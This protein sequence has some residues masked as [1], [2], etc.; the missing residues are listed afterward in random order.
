MGL[1]ND[2]LE[3]FG[4][5][6]TNVTGIKATDD[7]GDTMM[8]IRPLTVPVTFINHFSETAVIIKYQLNNSAS[9]PGVASTG[10]IT[11]NSSFIV[12]MSGQL[13]RFIARDAVLFIYMNSNFELH[14]GNTVMSPTIE[15]KKWNS[16]SS[17]YLYYKAYRVLSSAIPNTGGTIDIYESSDPIL[18]AVTIDTLSV[19]TNDTYTAPAGTAYSEVTVNVSGG[20]SP[21]LQTKSVTPTETAQV[22][23][24]DAGYDGLDEV[25][26]AAIS[27]S[28]VGSGIT[29][30][31]STDMTVSGATV[32]APS[33]YYS[34]SASETVSSGTEGTPTATKGTVSNHSVTITPSVTNTAGYIVGSTKT[35]TAVTVSAAELVSGTYVVDST[36]VKDVTDYASLLVN[37]GT[38]TAPS[39]IS[40]TSA[41][42]STGTNTLTLTKTVSVTPNVST[43]GYVSSGTAGNSSVSLTA[44]VTTKAAATITP[45]TTDQTIASGTYLTGAQTISGDANLVAG[46]IK[47]GTSIFGVTGTYQGGTSGVKTGT[48]SVASNVNTSTSTTITTTS[49]IGFTPTKFLF[50]KDS[51][52]ATNNH[53]HQATF[54]TIGSYYIRTMTRYSSNALSTSGNTNN[55][56]TQTA[57]YLYFNNN[58]IYF[59]SSSSYILSSGTWY[60]VAIE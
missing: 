8:Y 20:G 31:S 48:L 54:T 43:A 44:S 51:R 47:N 24:A 34:S 29:R 11:T 19:T 53:V 46:N 4:T 21:T 60:W 5:E 52:T 45:G 7:N 57:G 56:T 17:K 40:G 3:V 36:G 13:M 28:Y 1:A 37:A 59:R 41:S 27:S 38:A 50:W 16:S 22:I 18:E 32:T 12:P 58:T 39:S 25:D 23:T 30:R 10:F 15:F 55:W 2:T 14:A 9:Y 6:Y 35:G 33:G 26:V 49:A 42:V